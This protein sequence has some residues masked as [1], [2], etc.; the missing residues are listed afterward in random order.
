MFLLTKKLIT[1]KKIIFTIT[2]SAYCLLITIT[3]DAQQE[4]DVPQAVKSSFNHLFKD[5]Q[6]SSWRQVFGTYL[7]SFNQ[8]NA[9]RDAYFTKEGVFKGI[10]RFITPD[11]LPMMVKEKIDREFSDYGILEVYQYDCVENGLCFFA[12]LENRRHVLILKMT[13]DGEIIYI[14]KSRIKYDNNKARRSIALNPVYKPFY[15]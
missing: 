1:M 4:M 12:V 2:V 11:L 9:W 3:A 15:E 10:G 13:P 8:G 6:A 5:V 7:S 14:Q